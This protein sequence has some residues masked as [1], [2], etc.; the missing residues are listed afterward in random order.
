MPKRLEPRKEKKRNQLKEHRNER[1]REK[2][3]LLWA[4]TRIAI[5]TVPLSPSHLPSLLS[6]PPSPPSLSVDGVVLAGRRDKW[7]WE[8]AVSTVVEVATQIAS[9]GSNQIVIDGPQ[10]TEVSR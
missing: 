10:Y 2:E 9:Q 3:S 5:K 1:K 6:W 8:A 4:H 7:W